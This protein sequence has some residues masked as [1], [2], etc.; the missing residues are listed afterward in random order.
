MSEL[1]N[2]LQELINMKQEKPN[3]DVK[4]I[5]EGIAQR[6]EWNELGF[7]SKAEFEQF[8]SDNPYSNL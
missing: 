7:K 1:D 3:F 4:Q 5:W 8:I 6:K 2:L